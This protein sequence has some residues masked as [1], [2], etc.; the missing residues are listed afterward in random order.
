[1][2][3]RRSSRLAALA[4]G[5]AVML[6][7]AAAPAAAPASARPAGSIAGA[8][9]PVSRH[10]QLHVCG[11]RLCDEAGGHVQLRGMSTHGTQWY[12][13]CI[14][15]RSLDALADSQGAGGWG[16]DVLRV[17]TYVQE[18][19]YATNPRLFTKRAARMVRQATARGLYVVIDW[20]LLD[21]GDPFVNLARAK[22]FFGAMTQRFAD[23]DNVLYEIANEP[24]GVPWSR[25]RSYAEELIPVIRAADPDAPILVGTA[26]WSSF[27]V[28]DGHDPRQ[29]VRNPVRA[30]NIAYTFHFY[31][32][33]HG[34]DYRKALARASRRLPVFVTEFGTQRYTG[35]GP[36]DFAS[37][38][39]YLALMRK[40][41]ISWVSWNYSDDWRSGAAFE[42]GT[43]PD[44]PFD[45][46]AV[47]KPA[48]EWVR[49]RIRAGRA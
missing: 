10:G 30:D 21:P 43:C 24:N 6:A 28:S 19:G 9:T 13:G 23:Q 12:A 31:A 2:T 37:A 38:G 14:N 49:D 27:G 5:L 35:N 47:L 22:R 26:G 48:G 34:A 41:G 46:D 16:A 18:G 32:A 39:R 45:T 7:G 20:H 42:T 25:I 44:G 36:N 8:S 29:V 4:L 11:R 33:S 17:S 40:R 1:M 15:A 3:S